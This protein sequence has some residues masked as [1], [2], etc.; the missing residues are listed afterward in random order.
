M[1]SSPLLPI[2]KRLHADSDN[3]AGAGMYFFTKCAHH[4]EQRFGIVHSGQGELN[5][6]GFHVERVWNAIPVRHDGVVL[7]A[8]ILM[9]NQLHGI[10]LFG[11]VPDATVPTLGTIVGQFRSLTTVEYARKV[12]EGSF[13]RFDRTAWRRGFHDHIIRGEVSLATAHEYIA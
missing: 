4:M 6:A 9:P 13:P 5:D 3:Y 12:N 2:R 11:A 8:W 7:D 10:L 1:T